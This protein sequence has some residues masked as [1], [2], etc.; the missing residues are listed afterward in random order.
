[1]RPKALSPADSKS[2]DSC[3]LL[4]SLS[5]HL[6]PR[7]ELTENWYAHVHQRIIRHFGKQRRHKNLHQTFPGPRK[8]DF[9]TTRRHQTVHFVS[10]SPL[11][12]ETLIFDKVVTKR[13]RSRGIQIRSQLVQIMRSIF[14]LTKAFW[15]EILIFDNV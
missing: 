11:L 7:N 4:T 3:L 14:S 12:G 8:S 10:K 15:A 2:S 9:I 5:R 6:S 1:M 13:F